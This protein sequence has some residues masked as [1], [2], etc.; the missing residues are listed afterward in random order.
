MATAAAYDAAIAGPPRSTTAAAFDATIRKGPLV[1]A[2]TATATAAAPFEV[3]LSASLQMV[4]DNPVYALAAAF[5]PDVITGTIPGPVPLV[6][7][8]GMRL[9]AGSAAAWLRTDGD[10]TVDVDTAG[11]PKLDLEG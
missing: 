11:H 3:G 6:R 2:Q 10:P 8:P 5:A 1:A 9:A 4:G 7:H